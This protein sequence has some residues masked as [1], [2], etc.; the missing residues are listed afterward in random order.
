[1][2]TLTTT[3]IFN[4]GYHPLAPP[5]Q[6]ELPKPSTLTPKHITYPYIKGLGVGF[7]D[8]GIRKV[9]PLKD[10]ACQVGER[11]EGARSLLQGARVL[12]FGAFGVLGFGFRVC[13]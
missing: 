7:L 1:M 3:A 11:L 2:G 4:S 12:G 13:S 8:S 10:K 6:V 9:C 5:T